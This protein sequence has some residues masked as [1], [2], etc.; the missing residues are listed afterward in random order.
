VSDEPA[1]Q[2]LVDGPRPADSAPSPPEQR[3][4]RLIAF[5]HVEDVDRAGPRD[6]MQ[7][8]DP[9][10]YVLMVAQIDPSS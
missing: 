9:D 1:D 5:V 2:P 3:V 4:N 7:L 6:Q 10:G 8:A